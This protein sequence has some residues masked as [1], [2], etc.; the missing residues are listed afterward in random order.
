MFKRMIAASIAVMM[1]LALI[2]ASMAQPSKIQPYNGLIGAG[3]PLYGIKIY[4]EQLNLFITFDSHEK[5]KKQMAYADE[6]LAEALAAANSSDTGALDAALTQY[7][8][9][10]NNVNVSSI[11][12]GS[13]EIDD[14]NQAL[15]TIMN[16]PAVPLDN[17]DQLIDLYNHNIDVKYGMPFIYVNNT[18]TGEV[19]A[20]FAPPGQ[21]QKIDSTHLPP[22]LAKKG[23]KRATA[24]I[25]GNGSTVW[26][27]DASDV[28]T[29]N[30]TH[31][32]KTKGN[33]KGNGNKK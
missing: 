22:G 7:A 25:D 19:T 13:S 28:Y 4:A 2:P 18:T 12:N 26:P 33:G 1:L 9:Q 21:L 31:N 15:D 11:E 24:T 23:Y 32:N 20:Y 3:S 5:Q 17:A 8:Q 6:R 27:W 14:Q 10:M 29:Y 16:D 30:I